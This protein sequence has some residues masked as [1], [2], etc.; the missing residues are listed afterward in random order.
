MMNPFIIALLMII[1]FGD[2]QSC[3]QTKDQSIE[4]REINN[5]LLTGYYY[6]K[7]SNGNTH[8]ILLTE[9]KNS[10]C[11]NTIQIDRKYNVHLE[12][13]YTTP[14]IGDFTFRLYKEDVY[15]DGIL[16]FPKKT[17]VYISK[18]IVGLCVINSMK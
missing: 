7:I 15:V 5:N 10:T 18:S 6:I 2:Y 1:S 12:K 3:R 4:I 14:L 13:I 16:V 8:S 11:N 17:D 9:K